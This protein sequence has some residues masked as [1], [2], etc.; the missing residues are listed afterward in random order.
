MS[1]LLVR[2]AESGT[3]MTASGRGIA[4]RDSDISSADLDKLASGG[5]GWTYAWRYRKIPASRPGMDVV[6]M[7]RN[8]ASIQTDTVSVLAAAKAR[9]DFKY[10]LGFNEPDGVNQANMTP[11]QAANLW[12]KLQAT[13][14]ILG[15]PAPAVPD[16][17]W[18]RSFMTIA[19]A[20]NL[21]VDFIALHFYAQ[22]TDTN[23]VARIKTQV[24]AIRSHYGKPIWITEVGIID[25]RTSNIGSTSTNWAR[26]VKQMR[27]ITSMLDSL[28]YVVRYAWVADHVASAQPLL[29]WSEIYD[30]YG[31][32]TP[33]GTAYKN[34]GS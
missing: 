34:L 26:S 16:N 2:G 27:G 4:S 14:L 13:G 3:A 23:A 29:K 17:G 20:R 31:R 30:N 5:A 12:P 9:G 7:L 24:Q 32:I 33:L 21:R 8:A 11:T 22:L 19:K 18:L 28:P 10:L 25:R 1:A 6:P 15:S